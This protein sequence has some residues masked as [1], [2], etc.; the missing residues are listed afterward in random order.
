MSGALDLGNN[1][2]TGVLNSSS[3]QDASTKIYTN[4]IGA[5]QVSKAGDVISN[6]LDMNLN[7]II[8]IA[9]PINGQ[10]VITKNY[11]DTSEG[12]N[13]WLFMEIHSSQ[14]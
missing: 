12:K 6:K 1:R 4:N 11:L 2:T 7:N 3:A 5:L 14:Y 8:K 10:E 13:F 9:Y